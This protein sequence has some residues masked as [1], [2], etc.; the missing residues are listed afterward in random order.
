M[1][2]YSS[3]RLPS[4]SRNLRVSWTPSSPHFPGPAV[5]G[6]PRLC[7]KRA[8][9]SRSSQLPTS[10]ALQQLDRTPPSLPPGQNAL[11]YGL[12]DLR[13]YNSRGFENEDRR[14]VMGPRILDLKGIPE[15]IARGLEVVAEMARNLAGVPR[16][17]PKRR[18]RVKLTPVKGGT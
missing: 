13:Q 17:K 3:T 15:P 16:A 10:K 9:C 6:T 11:W 14:F 5:V 7:Q 2:Q 12:K 8:A 1:L 4:G 18:K